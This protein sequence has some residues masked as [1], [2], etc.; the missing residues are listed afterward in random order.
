M[1]KISKLWGDAI[2]N[3]LSPHAKLLYIYLCSQSTI[4]TL[5]VIRIN[6][7]K[8][9]GD[10]STDLK[11]PEIIYNLIINDFIIEIVES[12]DYHTFLIL[13]HFKSLAKSKANIR[14]AVDEGKEAKGELQ[15][16]LRGFFI[17]EDFE[18]NEFKPPTPEQVTEHAL[19]KGYT[20]NGK[21]FCEYYGDNDWYNKNNKK[22]RN[23]KA[24]L[25]RVWCREENKLVLVEG[26]PKGYE[27]FYVE[28]ES[29]ERISPESWKDG[30][31]NHSNFLY[32]ELLTNKFNGL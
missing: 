7:S 25:E 1:V 22:V 17:K 21:K 4:S 31:P 20:V 5:G 29:G 10:L 18:G 16:I 8:I 6:P 11:V 19:S 3:G 32:T 14:K 2:F 26:S 28:I 30:K 23:W 13:N 15:S 24:T 12:E 27:Y 9:L